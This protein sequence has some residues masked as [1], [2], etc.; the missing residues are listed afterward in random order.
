MPDQFPYSTSNR[1]VQALARGMVKI[2]CNQ[3]VYKSRVEKKRQSLLIS[4]VDTPL[5][6]QCYHCYRALCLS[7]L[8][9]ERQKWSYQ[10][11]EARKTLR[12]EVLYTENKI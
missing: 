12:V 7:R 8:G 1:S 6:I 4:S 3:N 2:F 9:A 11:Y 5:I 10:H